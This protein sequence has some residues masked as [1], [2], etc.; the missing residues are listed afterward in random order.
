MTVWF[1]LLACNTNAQWRTHEATNVAENVRFVAPGANR[2]IAVRVILKSCVSSSCSR[3]RKSSCTA[4]FDGA[5][6]EITSEF[7]WETR[8]G[9]CTTDCGT[10]ETTCTL[11]GGVP[12]LGDWPAE[13]GDAAL[14]LTVPQLEDT[15]G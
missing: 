5:R 2:D 14:T 6:I 7:S 10:I 1:L 13:H 4:S 3:N 8:G 11:V 12:S 9:Q 15:D